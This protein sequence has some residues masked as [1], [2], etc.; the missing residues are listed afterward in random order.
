M[1]MVLLL[2]NLEAS[3][4]KPMTKADSLRV[5]YQNA[6]TDTA[7]IKILF[8][9][10][11]QFLNGP[12]DSLIFHFRKS[13]EIAEKNLQRIGQ[14][15]GTK[16]AELVVTY[17][18]L[19][20]RAF[21]E[22]GIEYFFQSNYPL[23][24]ENFFKGLEFSEEIDDIDLI[25]EC[26]SEIG[27]VYKNQGKY[28]EALKFDNKALKYAE[29]GT[30]TSWIASC[31][32]NNGS[33]YYQK[34]SYTVALKNYLKALKIFE[35]L[36][37]NKRIEAC[38]LNIGKVYYEQNDLDKAMTYFRKAL[39]IAILEN[40]KTGEAGCYLN[41]GGI[42]SDK[43]QYDS[44]RY[45]LNKSVELSRELGYKH[46]LDDCYSYI[47]ITY[48]KENKLGEALEFYNKA[49]KISREED[50]RP[51][52][53]ESLGNIAGIYY[54]QKQYSKALNKALQGLDI[55]RDSGN[56]PI[57]RN[58]YKVVSQIYEA[59]GNQTVALKY[60]K[61]YSRVKDTLFNDGKY[62]A[63][64]ELEA[65]FET[66]KKEQQLALLKEQSRVQDLKI[67][68][69]NRMMLAFLFFFILAAIAIYLY[70]RNKRL[71]SK[72]KNIELEQKLLRSQ[73]NPHFIFNSLIAIQSFIYNND[74]ILA[75]DYLAKF[76]D[77]VRKILE[78]SRIESITLENEV[79]TIE[80]YLEL[81]SLRFENKFNY[82]IEVESEIDPQKIKLPPMLAQP[83]IE[84]AIEHG[85]RH[86][87]DKG[88]LFIGFNKIEN[89]LK[90]TVEDDGIGREKAKEIERARKHK[91]LAMAIVKERID[92]LSKKFNERFILRVEDLYDDS[93]KAA[94][95]RIVFEI[96]CL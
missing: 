12:S 44:A 83:F 30:D 39:D 29:M 1:V 9:I 91:S 27:I 23:A 81:Q 64:R 73:M 22:I 6:K 70:F 87:Q 59:M 88:F 67:I 95:T 40:E 84:N 16:N 20:I 55:A 93:G 36:G 96:P 85:L 69:R 3:G 80:L 21:I 32:V 19:A 66:E 43:E 34:G 33:I 8:K 68:Q 92:I 60:F 86:R 46:G 4:S 71:K 57:M 78:N 17:K 63:I 31:F 25:S 2:W 24:L 94:G 28:E 82:K 53:A 42:F 35:L 58:V 5:E 89:H 75:G 15:G 76:A 10:G 14:A 37:H 61:L 54:L 11:Y 49:L 48:L 41:I 65:K 56:L 51:G 62:R 18:K 45:Y 38:Y 52:I 79:K 90:L 13:L 50:D 77:L 47:G 72:H 26:A 7:R 74:A